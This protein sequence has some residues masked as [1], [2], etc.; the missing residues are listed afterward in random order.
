MAHEQRK[1]MVSK[2]VDLVWDRHTRSR[3]L[4]A[5]FTQAI[6]KPQKSKIQTRSETSPERI[7][8]EP[9]N[10]SESK[11]TFYKQV[12]IYED[13]KNAS[14][15]NTPEEEEINTNLAREEK[16]RADAMGMDYASYLVM[17]SSQ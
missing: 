17:M 15:F 14:M 2:E 3:Q 11:F 8:I 7:L 10:G 5:S 9:L 6:P 1:A 12:F 4:R 13:F 16:K